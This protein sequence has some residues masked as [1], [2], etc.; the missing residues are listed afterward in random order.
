MNKWLVEYTGGSLQVAGIQVGHSLGSESSFAFQVSCCTDPEEIA[1][2]VEHIQ[3]MR[4]CNIQYWNSCSLETRGGITIHKMQGDVC[5]IIVNN[6]RVLY[7][8]S[9]TRLKGLPK[10][11]RSAEKKLNKRNE[12]E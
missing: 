11:L 8:G 10:A 4:E 5:S 6:C 12:N 2:A 3:S 9:I 7:Q 1:C